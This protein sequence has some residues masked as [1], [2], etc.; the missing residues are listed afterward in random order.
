MKIILITSK[1]DFESGG[2]SSTELDQKARSLQEKGYEVEVITAFSKGNKPYNLLY[3]VHEENV[4]SSSLFS[5]QKG[6]YEILKK[7]EAQ[8]NIFHI[9]GQFSYGGGIY[10]MK[11]GKIPIVVHFN[12]ELSSFP[13]TRHSA[14]NGI[15]QKF[16][17]SLERLF[18]FPLI[19][20]C[21]AFTFTS[22]YIKAVYNKYGLS[23]DKSSV[24]PDFFDELEVLESKDLSSMLLE[25]RKKEKQIIQILSTGR[26]VKEKG[27]DVL[28]KAFAKLN[29]K[30]NFKLII[31]GDGPQKDSLSKL[32]RELGIE[33]YIE[34]PG[35]IEKQDLSKLFQESDIF[36]LPRWRPELTSMLVLEAMAFAIP[37]IVTKDT[38]LSWQT[39]DSALLFEDENSDDLSNQIT[40]MASDSNKRFSLASKGIKRLKELDYH[41]S[42]DKLNGILEKL[43]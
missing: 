18:G 11:K 16:R 13:D 40:T 8:T 20:N 24:V 28:I 14:K 6:I 5:I 12:R 19:N 34:F 39:Q 30:E 37:M 10:K 17:L 15:K 29:N 9:E 26:M 3:K 33:K 35:W 31:S 42:V 25:S 41:N 2:G 4:D 38:A 43:K 32:A 23:E 22:P 1:F 7:Y 27:F 21:N 36:V